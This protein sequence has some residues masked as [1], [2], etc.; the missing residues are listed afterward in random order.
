MRI[1]CLI[2]K[3]FR[4]RI[5]FFG[6]RINVTLFITRRA[7]RGYS[8]AYSNRGWGSSFSS[9]FSFSFCLNQDTLVWKVI[10]MIFPE[11]YFLLHL[12][13]QWCIEAKT[14]SLKITIRFFH[15]GCFYI[16]E[17]C[18]GLQILNSQSVRRFKNSQG[19]HQHYRPYNFRCETQQYRPA[20]RRTLRRTE[21]LGWFFLNFIFYFIS[22]SRD[23]SRL[24]PIH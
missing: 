1:F 13:K 22:I 12:N 3:H 4:F 11:F 10:R 20:K 6:Q 24:K 5:H 17:I 21:L 7:L 9:F 15:C 19:H 23:A 2:H 14:N 8:V 16:T 18:S